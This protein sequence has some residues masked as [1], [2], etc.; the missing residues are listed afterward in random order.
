MCKV[1]DDND[2]LF[3]LDIYIGWD[4][5]NIDIPNNLT[6]H[7]HFKT[8]VGWVVSPAT[9]SITKKARALYNEHILP[10]FESASTPLCKM[11]SKLA[12]TRDDVF[13][14]QSE[15]QIMRHLL[16][17]II[18]WETYC[19]SYR[20]LGHM[21]IKILKYRGLY[22][23][24][25]AKVDENKKI[26]DV[27]RVMLIRSISP[28]HLP[29]L[30]PA[31]CF[32]IVRAIVEDKNQVLA[33]DYSQQTMGLPIYQ[34]FLPDIHKMLHDFSPHFTSKTDRLY[35]FPCFNFFKHMEQINKVCFE[36]SFVNVLAW[37]S[38]VMWT[39]VCFCLLFFPFVFVLMTG[40]KVRKFCKFCP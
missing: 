1:V 3:Y 12:P 37:L 33:N 2:Y 18:D 30:S 29:D 15:T 39:G 24:Y 34:S 38:S 32:S 26:N 25:L 22:G 21:A 10:Q 9:Q 7:F 27:F 16:T 20:I 31:Q 19:Q 28:K 40:S 13:K 23:E 14:D 36:F 17:R 11:L 6:I 35:L 8:D 4:N 5:P